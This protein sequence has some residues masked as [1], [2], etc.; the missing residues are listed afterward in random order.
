MATDRPCL[1]DGRRRGIAHPQRTFVYAR[2]CNRAGRCLAEHG[3]WARSAAGRG[4]GL[5]VAHSAIGTAARAGQCPVIAEA[6]LSEHPEDL[7]ARGWRA[8][9]LAW[10]NRWNESEIEYRAVLQSAPHDTDILVGLAD[11]LTWQG[12]RVEAMA[13]LDQASLLDAGRNDVH[14]R[15]G[16]L[17]HALGRRAEAGVAYA[18]VFSLKGLF[19]GM[20]E[21]S[22]TP[23]TEFFRQDYESQPFSSFI[24]LAGS[25]GTHRR[26]GHAATWWNARDP[27]QPD[28]AEFHLGGQP[29]TSNGMNYAV[30]F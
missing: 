21:R 19:V 14:L 3:L 4:G 22:A 28:L 12:Q 30:R 20:D 24:G 11:L 1:F 6:R 7:E 23:A 13:F 8:R 26:V 9:L 18:L 2:S 29:Q 5:A 10:T 25:F 16:R 27:R 15:R 17:L